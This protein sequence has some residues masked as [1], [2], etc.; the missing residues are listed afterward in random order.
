VVRIFDARFNKLV[1]TY[2]TDS[3]GRYKFDLGANQYQ[4]EVQREGYASYKS[5]PLDLTKVKNGDG[6]IH[7]DKSVNIP[8]KSSNR[9]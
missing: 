7:L 2:V 9:K 4:M 8:L 6:V 1:G 3:T 5:Q